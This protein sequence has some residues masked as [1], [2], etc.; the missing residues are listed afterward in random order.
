MPESA[1][2]MLLID[3]RFTSY[4]ERYSTP[5]ARNHTRRHRQQQPQSSN[6]MTVFSDA[7]TGIYAQHLAMPSPQR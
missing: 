3:S 7:Y 4:L 2:N 1:S 6:E 5:L